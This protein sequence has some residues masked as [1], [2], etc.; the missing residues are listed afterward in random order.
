MKIVVTGAGGQIAYALIFQIAKGEVFGSTQSISLY[1]LEI[2]EAVSSL[3]GVKMELEDCGFPLLKEVQ[4]GSDPEKIFEGADCILFI[5]A[6]PRGPG[7]ERKDLL[8]ENA[9][10]FAQQGKVLGRVA[11]KNVFSFVVGNPCNTN[12]LILAHNAPHIP[13]DRFHAMTRLDQQRAIFQLAK[14]AKVLLPDVKDVTIWGN[15]SST[16]VPDYLNAK[17]QGK[18]ATSFLEISWLQKEWMETIQQRG[19]KVIAARGKSSAASAAHA[20]SLSL[21]S[22]FDPSLK[23]ESFSSAVW[24][25]GNPY[26]IAEGLFFSFPCAKTHLGS[27]K[28]VPGK[29]WDDFTQKKI[30]ESE[31]ELLTERDLVRHLLP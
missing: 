17:I 6:K 8:I 4:F 13:K 24:S 31:R 30:K 27:Y 11:Q 9:I 19:A 10:I 5:G 29:I 1:L 25:D 12:A 18:K 28:I 2:P 20:I 3:E 22:L 14:K 21:R 26:G 16:Q 7:M 23:E 15:H